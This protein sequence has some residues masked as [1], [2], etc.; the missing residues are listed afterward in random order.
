MPSIERD[1]SRIRTGR[2]WLVTGPAKPLPDRDDELSRSGT[3]GRRSGAGSGARP[4][5][6]PA[7]PSRVYA[8]RLPRCWPNRT[9]ATGPGPH[10]ANPDLRP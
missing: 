4:Q 2:K 6:R 8:A 3:T 7:A 9:A 5:V 1:Q 10:L